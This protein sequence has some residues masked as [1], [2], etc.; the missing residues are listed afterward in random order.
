MR[1]ALMIALL[2]AATA[3]GPCL[4]QD[5]DTPDARTQAALALQQAMGGEAAVAKTFTALRP[6]LIKMLTENAHMTL[7]RAAQMVDEVEI[8]DLEKD[9]PGMLA[10]R[11]RIY[12]K[13]FSTHDLQVM[14]AFYKSPT[15]QKLL[16]EQGAIAAE[17]VASLQP[18][19]RDVQAHA[20]ALAKKQAQGGTQTP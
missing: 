15:G 10:S 3:A 18:F 6:T 1:N 4:A 11:A 17:Y 20:A 16:A 19:M 8:P 7:S 2:A 9:A 14:L 12:A 5:A 13:Y